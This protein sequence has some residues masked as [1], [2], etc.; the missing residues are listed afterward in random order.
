MDEEEVARVTIVLVDLM[1]EEVLPLFFLVVV[2]LLAKAWLFVVAC[3]LS[4]TAK[5]RTRSWFI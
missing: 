3:V 5:T 1:A 2:L 4:S